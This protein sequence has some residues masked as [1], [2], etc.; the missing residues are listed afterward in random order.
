MTDFA[1]R[2]NEILTEKVL[3]LADVARCLGLDKGTVSKWADAKWNITP[4]RENLVNLRNCGFTTAEVNHLLAAAGYSPLSL[5]EIAPLPPPGDLERYLRHVRDRQAILDFSIFQEG[6]EQDFATVPL[7]TFY[8]PLRLAGRP[9]DEEKDLKDLPNLPKLQLHK[10]ESDIPSNFILTPSVRLGHHLVLLGDAGS[11]K[12]TLLRQL[13]GALAQAYLEN[14][15]E[16]A[17]RRTGVGEE[18]LLPLFVPLRYYHHYCQTTPGRTLTLGSFFDFL[19]FHFREQFGLALPSDF[20]PTLLRSGRCLLTLDGFDEVPDEVSRLQVAALVRNLAADSVLGQNRIILSSRVAAYGGPAQLGGSFKTLWVQPLNGEERA[21]QIKRWVAGMAPHTQ[22]E[23]KA[24]DMLRPMAEGSPLDELAVT[25][26]IVT[27]LCVV[28]FYD[29][30]LPEQRAQLYR[31]CVDIMLREKLR[32]DE[33]GQSLADQGGKPDF[34]RDLLARLAFEMHLNQEEEANKEQ[35]AHWLKDGFRSTPP[36]ERLEEAY[37]F[38]NT[39]TRRGTLLQ[40]RAGLFSFG[41]Q[42][43]TFREFLAGYHLIKGLP[44]GQRQALWP[45]LLQ[46]DWWREPI[47]LA[48][49]A[50]VFEFSLTCEDFL[51][52]L[53]DQA[54]TPG[55]DPAICLAGYRLAAES[56]VDMGQS[57]RGMLAFDLQ[58]Q[59]IEGLAHRLFEDPAI[60]DPQAGLLKERVAAAEALGRLGDPREGVIGL[61]P[62]LTPLIQGK[63]LYGTDADKEECEVAPFRAGVYPITNAQFEVFWRDG[64]YNNQDWW[65]SKGWKWRQGKRAYDWQKMDQPDFWDDERFNR[66]NQPVVGVTWYEAEAFCNWLTVSYGR[67]YRLPTEAEWERLARGQDGREYPWG[68]GWHEGVSNTSEADL[69]QSTAVGL[70]PGGVSPAGAQDCVGNI[71]EWCA[72]RYDEKETAR[73]LRG[74][75]WNYDQSYARCA[76]RDRSFPYVSSNYIGFRVVS[77]NR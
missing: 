38:L 45:R 12:T 6:S 33:P 14:D 23:L 72:N 34:K 15:L 24:E 67:D 36:T 1:A 10:R 76:F 52:E 30:K 7:D 43:R 4:K 65:S 51:K 58:S 40:E 68:E 48:A 71:W 60:F 59:I 29:H 62:L 9:F 32:P 55:A 2:F 46:A 20:F 73:A 57:G 13:T 18:W 19:P 42:H 69:G 49:G 74:G 61:P 44:F 35:T 53:L 39:I 66:P 8:I 3:S 21:E 77:P 28:Y 54:D 31:R 25:P 16:F 17:R 75:S 11:G 56:L 63:F 22:K 5:Q 26:M 50:T 70:F 37:K 41:R 27:A 64:G 47:R